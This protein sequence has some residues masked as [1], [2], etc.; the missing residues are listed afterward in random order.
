[1]LTWRIKQRSGFTAVQLY[2]D[3][4][5]AADFG[6]LAAELRGAV[7]LELGEVRRLSSIGVR[8]WIAF[9]NGLD[10]VTELVLSHCSPAIVGQL[11]M[12]AGFR[13]PADIRS[14]YAPYL[15]PACGAEQMKLIDIET[16]GPS[17]DRPPTFDCPACGAAM[18][19]DDL[20]ERYLAF[21]R[22][23]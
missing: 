21:L 16:H 13:G 20:P 10:R 3:I 2:G 7:V 14:F 9:V 11:G 18:E 1:M 8:E 22:S 23:R 12:V 6:E 4:D 19:L 5:D 17:P 15:C